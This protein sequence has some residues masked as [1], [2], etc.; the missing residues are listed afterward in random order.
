MI[1]RGINYSKRVIIKK[2]KKNNEGS[3]YQKLINKY[4]YE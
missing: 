2:K 4:E 3:A 1:H